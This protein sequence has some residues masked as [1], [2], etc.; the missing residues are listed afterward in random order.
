MAADGVA[1]A[2]AAGL[3]ALEISSQDWDAY[4]GAHPLGHHEQSSRF[5]EM[6]ARNGY[7][8]VR[9]G[10]VER[11]GRLCA[12]LQL[13]Y[14]SLPAAGRLGLVTQGPLLSERR[15]D[16]ARVLLDALEAV[17]LRYR[18]SRIRVI[19]YNANQ[20]WSPLL[21]A[22][23]FA[24]AGYAWAAEHSLLVRCDQSDEAILGRMKSKCRYNL[25]LAQRKGVTVQVGE[26]ADI[27]TFYKLL[28]Q[29]AARQGFPTFPSDYLRYVWR[30][31]AAENKARLFIASAD[32]EPLAGVFATVCG[33]R[34]FYGWG[35]L[36]PRRR[37]LMANYVTHWEAIRWA[38]SIG[39]KYYDLAG[40]GADDGVDQFKRRWGGEPSRYPEPMDKYYGQ[41]ASLRQRAARQIS[42]Q[43][44]LRNLADRIVLHRYGK[45][46]C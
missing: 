17:A 37:K 21:A 33:E 8:S 15:P 31:F 28:C 30:L 23:G 2:G 27:D 32:G 36:S 4:L 20:I 25:R 35:G 16:A 43:D 45:M 46:P 12:G 18:L 22:R 11:D 1:G 38:R 10:V 9:L 29:T 13:L 3:L 42:E 34:V 5:A 39:K 14:R 7:E 6:R 24:A 26:E 40:G 41:L 19:N 44:K